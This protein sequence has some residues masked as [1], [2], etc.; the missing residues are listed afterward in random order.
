MADRPS[1]LFKWVSANP[2]GNIDAMWKD[3]LAEDVDEKTRHLWYH[4]LHWLINEG[5]ALLFADGKLHAAKEL[6]KP[7]APVAKKAAKP[8][9]EAAPKADSAESKEGK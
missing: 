6:D 4:D 5:F 8:K 9:K 3:L 1:A 7:A 2:A